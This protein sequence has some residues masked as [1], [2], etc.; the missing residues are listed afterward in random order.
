MNGALAFAIECPDYSVHRL[1]PEDTESL[2]ELFI[3]CADYA[4]IVTGEA[5]SPAAAEQ[6]FKLIPA[7]KSPDDKFVFGIVDRWK[8]I[9]GVLEGMRNYPEDDAWWIGLLML[10]PEVRRQGIGRTILDGFSKY[11][12]SCNGSAI[13][14]G[15]VEDNRV[16]Y[17]FWRAVGFEVVRKTEPHR[18]GKKTQAVYIM[19]RAVEKDE[20][21]TPASG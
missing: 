13:M 12:R 19:R 16:A 3:K 15:V 4:L 1:V 9:V 2:Q 14:L 17:S 21:S 7:G 10:A 20:T 11:V 5:V 18:Y 6:T 8:S